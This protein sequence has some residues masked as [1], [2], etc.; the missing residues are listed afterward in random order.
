MK[1][2]T[3]NLV[4][5]VLL[6]LARRAMPV[7]AAAVALFCGAARLHADDTA[8][9]K[10]TRTFT[11]GETGD[12]QVKLET[13]MSAETYT[14]AKS[15]N[16]NT[17]VL[18][19]RLMPGVNW[20]KVENVHGQF[21]DSSSTVTIEY[22][23][24]GT[25]RMSGD[26]DWEIAMEVDSKLDL[27]GTFDN[28]AVFSTSCQTDLG[29]ASVN[30]KIVAPKTAT[31]IQ[32]QHSPEKVT[33]HFTPSPAQG[34]SPAAS[35]SLDTRA[36]VMPSLAKCYA[37]SRLSGLWVARAVL[38]N[39]GDQVLSDYRVRF[40]MA[41]YAEW[42]DAKRSRRVLPGQTVVD[43]YFPLFDV[44]RLAAVTS[45][46]PAMVEVEYEYRQQDGRT[47]RE[48][49][50]KQLQVLGR[51][52]VV[53]SNLGDDEVVGF[54]DKYNLAPVILSA[55][56]AGD[57]TVMTEL[58]SRLN[59]VAGFTQ[60]ASKDSEAEKFLVNLYA[61]LANNKVTL[62]SPLTQTLRYG[63]D[64]LL[65]RSGTYVDLA[66]LYASACEAAG[67][68][69]SLNLTSSNCL[70][71]IRLPEGSSV[72]IDLTR[73]SSVPYS[74]AT[75]E[76]ESLLK[77][78]R[79]K[80]E[81]SQIDVAKWRGLGVQ[82]ADLSKFEEGFLQKNYNFGKTSPST[83]T[84]DL[85]KFAGRWT[86]RQT[87]EGRTI[88]YTLVLSNDG[89]YT[90]RI[91]ITAT[92]KPTSDLQEAGTFSLSDDGNL[93]NFQPSDGK[94]MNVYTYRLK[95]DELDLQVQGSGTV[96]TFQRSK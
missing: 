25:V 59:Q 74:K 89:K 64:V 20:A 35:F 60:V 24:L 21:D 95:G 33:Y 10:I 83:D 48:G 42:S 27:V 72:T 91:L 47:V 84:K 3:C 41:P 7:L 9:I 68:K 53:F 51:N 8:A 30:L 38:K 34:T 96:V 31:N 79:A 50:S 13:K 16:P 14:T 67:L 62:Q 32:L 22:T 70:P 76:G 54:Y 56:V 87:P 65:N 81:V 92:G 82:S 18:L 5:G 40:R 93:L 36:K 1:S 43:A 73:L 77:G 61:F 75:D 17:A 19:R 86:L 94:T 71:T 44:E 12:V 23:Q 6:R 39:T 66:I 29:S 11:V 45:V 46:R 37:D 69:T 57:D 28:T 88:E 49:T 2:D 80:Q 78:A 58:V 63:R 55:F 52:Q 4:R 26:D 90:Y 85:G 15:N